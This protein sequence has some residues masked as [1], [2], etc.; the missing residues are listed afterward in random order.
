LVR[1]HDL[2]E[3]E[4]P[5]GGADCAEFLAEDQLAYPVAAPPSTSDARV[6]P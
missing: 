3:R 2:S 6:Q 5:R 1:D 4:Y